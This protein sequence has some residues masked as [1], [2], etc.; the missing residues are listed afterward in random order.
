M[1][2]VHCAWSLF[3]ADGRLERVDVAPRASATLTPVLAPGRYKLFCSLYAGTAQ[4]HE[5][6]GMRFELEVR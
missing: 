3:T 2:T 1:S 4:S 5:A 6:L